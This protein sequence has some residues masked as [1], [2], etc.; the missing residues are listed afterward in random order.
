MVLI[1]AVLSTLL[2]YHFSS[3]LDPSSIKSSLTQ[4]IR[5]FLWEG[6]KTNRKRFHLVIWQV[7]IDPKALGGM[8]IKEAS[9]VNLV[10]G[11]KLLWRMLTEK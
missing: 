4:S 11:A 10:L 2:D 6:G 1:K 8:G 3:L 9:L 5:K 7:V